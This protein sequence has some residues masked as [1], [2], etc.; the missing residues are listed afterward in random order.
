MG[1]K[2]RQHFQCEDSRGGILAFGVFYNEENAQ[3]AWRDSI[4]WTQ[5]QIQSLS[6]LFGIE[7]GVTCIRLTDGYPK[8]RPMPG[9]IYENTE[10]DTIILK[11]E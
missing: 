8:V 10:L 9:Y 4:G 2:R 5:E 11:E 7:A 1:N 6:K 3:I